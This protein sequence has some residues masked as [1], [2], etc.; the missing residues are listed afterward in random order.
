MITEGSPFYFSGGHFSYLKDQSLL[1][2][3]LT[4]NDFSDVVKKEDKAV[5]ESRINGKLEFISIQ[6]SKYSQD[7]ESIIKKQNQYSDSSIPYFETIDKLNQQLQRELSETKRLIDEKRTLITKRDSVI[8]ELRYS[9]DLLNRFSILQKQYNSD[10]DRLSFILEAD[11]LSAQIGNVVCPICTSTLAEDHLLHVKEVENFRASATEELKKIKLKLSDL[12]DTTTVLIGKRGTY[13]SEAKAFDRRIEELEAEIQKNFTPKI[14]G[15]KADM[16][17]FI[18]YESLYN[19]ICFIDDEVDKLYKEKDR[20][21]KQLG[22]KED[23]DEINL[24]QYSTLSELSDYIQKRLQRWNYELNAKV[25]F[26]SSYS[27]FDIV[28]SGKSRRSY[29]KGKRSISFSA[30]M[31]GILDFCLDKNQPFSNLIVLDSPLTTFEDKKGA[32]KEGVNAAIQSS[33][34]D[35]LVNTSSNSQIIIF[36][37]KEPSNEIKDKINTIVFTGSKENGR[38]GFFPV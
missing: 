6:L 20:L 36:D 9:N 2:L 21:E 4:G 24:L 29:G 23:E 33:F 27:V 38:A 26:D 31:F 10:F 28:I 30:C 8:N 19:R 13:E 18:K 15:L 16:K 12:A 17:H 25:N 5:K 3:I 11:S 1:N 34:F 32:V 14:D 22:E 37:N 35:D 7:R